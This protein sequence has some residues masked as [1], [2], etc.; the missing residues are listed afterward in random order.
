M[1]ENQQD[2]NAH[3]IQFLKETLAKKDSLGIL[4]KLYNSKSEYIQ[5][6][7]ISLIDLHIQELHDLQQELQGNVNTAN[8]VIKQI[9]DKL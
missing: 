9:K 2:I 4:K 8:D 3:N 7:I 5:S 6:Y 1:I